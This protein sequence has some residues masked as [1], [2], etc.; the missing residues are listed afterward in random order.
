MHA[1]AARK[2]KQI[3][4]LG[5][6]LNEVEIMV[7]NFLNCEYTKASVIFSLIKLYLSD[8]HAISKMTD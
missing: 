6:R 2:Q 4:R 3:K 1:L 5:G 8:G 7:T